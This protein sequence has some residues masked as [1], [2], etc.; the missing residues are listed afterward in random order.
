M[1]HPNEAYSQLQTDLRNTFPRVPIVVMNVVN[2]HF[3]YL[4]SANLYCKNIYPVWQSP[5]G[6]GS[7]ETLIEVVNSTIEGM[8]R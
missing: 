8:Q 5:F 3:G 6:E 7:L 4:P 1:G 2:G